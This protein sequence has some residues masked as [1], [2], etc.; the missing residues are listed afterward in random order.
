MSVATGEFRIASQVGQRGFFGDVS[1]NADTT[2]ND[3]KITVLFDEEHA[4]RWRGGAQFGIDYVLEHISKK[5]YFPHGIKIFVNRITGHE[6]DTD[7][8]LIAFVTARAL[9]QAL[10]V[11][12][13][14]KLP[15]LDE[16]RGLVVF[17]K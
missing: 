2:V 9:L 14:K 5:Q 10:K 3:G 6:V 12:E 4:S 11:E 8:A 1:L 7:S 17:P 16:S 15:D 13:P